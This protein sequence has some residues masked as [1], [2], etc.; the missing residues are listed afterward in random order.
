MPY[1]YAVCILLSAFLLFQ[2]QPMMGK[3]IAPWFG[4]SPTVWSTALLFFQVLLTGGYAYAYWL[5]G[6]LRNRV[7]GIVHLILLGLSLA[8]LLLTALSWPSPLTPDISWRPEVGDLPIWGI[9]RILAVAIGFPYLLL[10]S[11][12]TLMQAWFNR[13]HRN[14][15]PYRLYALSNTGSLVALISY[16]IFFEPY[17]ALRTQAYVWSA[18][19]V[20]YA[21]S[22]AFLA[23]RTFRRPQEADDPVGPTSKPGIENRPSI[24]MLLLWIGLAASASTLLISV[25]S[26]ITQEVAVIPFLWIVPLTIYL[27]SFI[28][29]FSGGPWYSRRWY[30]IAFFVVLVATQ[31]LLQVPSS[32][33]IVQIIIYSLGLFISCMMCHGELYALRPHPRFLPSFY[34]M[35]ALGGALGGVFVTLVAPFLFSNGFWELQ[36]G[37]VASAVLLAIIMHFERA[38]EKRK[39]RRRSRRAGAKARQP[40]GPPSRVLKPIVIAMSVGILLL[41]AFVIYKMVSMSSETV[42]ATRNFYG[43]LRVWE[44]DPESDELRSYQLTHGK[45]AH[46]FQFENAVLSDLP[47]TYYSETSG[48]GLALLDHPSRPGNLRVGGLGLGIGVI[49]TYGEPGD[50]F[51][52]YEIN[53]DVILFAEGEGGYFSFLADSQAEVHVIEG[54]ARISLERELNSTGAHE[55]DLI[56]LD[57]FSGDTMPIHLLTI[58]AFEIYLQHLAQDGIIAINASNRYFNLPFEIYRL[59]DE[60]NLSTAL[61]ED[62]G[63]GVQGYDSVWVLLSR[64]PGIL[65]LPVFAERSIPRPA[66]PANIR[67]WTDDFHNLLRIL[68]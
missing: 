24:G 55:F 54:D 5:L 16:P 29:A 7:Q 62:R 32:S 53:P 47:T 36:W 39:R 63:D 58:E 57:A 27:L 13:D 34:L 6:R 22:A 8:L 26:Q 31:M 35:I 46:G 9:L 20:I 12:S 30:L 11:N 45:T 68:R 3:L 41:S 66:I 10:S 2:I 67:A 61:I 25:T 65:E 40:S 19:Y 28:L 33:L 44:N 23:V 60:F 42:M 18:A 37:L 64:E 50:D 15:T 48:V 59:A 43:V 38:P 1:Y 14:P 51:R 49:A 21:I 56:V 4:G 52:F 17:L